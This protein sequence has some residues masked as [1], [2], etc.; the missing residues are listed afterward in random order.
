MFKERICKQAVERLHVHFLGVKRT[1][2]IFVCGEL[3]RMP[4]RMTRYYAL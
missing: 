2:R 4:L 3:G 1:H